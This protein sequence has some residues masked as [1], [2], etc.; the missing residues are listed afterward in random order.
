MKLKY[1]ERIFWEIRNK[2]YSFFLKN[3]IP[4]EELIED[5]LNELNFETSLYVLDAGCGF[6]IFEKKLIEKGIIKNIKIEAIDISKKIIQIAKKNI[7]LYENINLEVMD[8]NEKLKFNDEIFDAIICINVIYLV[9]DPLN[10]LLEFYRVLKKRGKL[11]LTTPKYNFSYLSLLKEHFQ[12]R[13]GLGKIKDVI[14]FPIFFP[15]EFFITI[16]EKLRKY[17]RFKEKDIV[18]L[19]QTV[20]FKVVKIKDSYAKQNF[21]V[22]AEK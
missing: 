2:V 22:V 10:T 7:S 9:K 13:K 18:K 20:P 19:F 21:F 8:L 14:L 11:I 15:F 17:H 5:I 4:Y 16:K 1:W 6:G 3:F 12:K